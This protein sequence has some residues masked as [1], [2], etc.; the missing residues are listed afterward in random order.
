MGHRGLTRIP[1]K[2]EDCYYVGTPPFERPEKAVADYI[3]FCTPATLPFD[4][5]DATELGE[6][7][8]SLLVI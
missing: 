5:M 8:Q 6:R 4:L 1:V 2:P 3:S 7:T